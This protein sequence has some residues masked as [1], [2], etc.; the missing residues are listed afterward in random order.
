MVAVNR[1]PANTL[2]SFTMKINLRFFF[3]AHLPVDLVLFY[4]F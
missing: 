2:F 1:A 4:M 3:I